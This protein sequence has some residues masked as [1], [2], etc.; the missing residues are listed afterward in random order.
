MIDPAARYF[1]D[2]VLFGKFMRLPPHVLW[3]DCN[4]LTSAVGEPLQ[5]RSV[6]HR[7]RVVLATSLLADDLGIGRG[8][9][10]LLDVFL[11]LADARRV[12]LGVH[13]TEFRHSVFLK[14]K[15]HV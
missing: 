14:L 11:P 9:L 8:S 4:A 15:R 13:L 10:Q 2:P 3:R 5:Q 7:E 1:L 12:N 6:D